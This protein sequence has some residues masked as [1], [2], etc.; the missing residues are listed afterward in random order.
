[1]CAKMN[2]ALAEP[3]LLYG[4]KNCFCAIIN[5]R[6]AIMF[7]L[8]ICFAS[9]GIAVKAQYDNVTDY[10]DLD[11]IGAPPMFAN[12]LSFYDF[13][14][15]GFDDLTFCVNNDSIICYQNLGGDQ[16]FRS[17]I[18][19]NVLD[20]KQPTWVDYDNDGDADLMISKRNSG[21]KLYRNDG[22]P[23]FTDVTDNL[24][25]PMELSAASYG[26]AWADYDV[27]GYL[28]CYVANYNWGDGIVR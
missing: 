1:M 4:P 18:L 11:F 21:L 28:D 14:K 17:E 27:D 20:A 25:V 2:N 16:F 5:C 3:A 19:P 15:D 26:C 8:S 9:F 12:G 13:N 24:D 7:F 22:Y 23:T 10:Y 6:V